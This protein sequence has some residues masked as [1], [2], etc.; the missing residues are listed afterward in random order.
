MIVTHLAL[1]DGAE[2]A[3]G[4]LERGVRAVLAEEGKVAAEL[5]L[6]LVGD[7]A[8]R[9]LSADHLGRDHATDVI[10]FALHE[11]GEAPL[12]DIYIGREVARRQARAYGVSFREELLRLAIHGAL[13]VLGYDHPEG[14]GRERSELF[15]KQERLVRTVMEGA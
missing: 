9:R 13:H 1:G 11:E 7:E 14:E 3:R 5:S 6:T 2:E 15:R 10:S 4:L 8:I 12:G